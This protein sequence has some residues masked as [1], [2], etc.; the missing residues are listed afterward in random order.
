[1]KVY[2]IGNSPSMCFCGRTQSKSKNNN[3]TNPSS[4]VSQGVNTAGAWF[5]FGVALDYVSRKLSFFKSPM[6]NSLA[7]NGTIGAAAGLYTGYK[8]L[9]HKNL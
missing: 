2:S 6:K 9:N 5:G 4:P 7:I 8:A 1:M 3:V